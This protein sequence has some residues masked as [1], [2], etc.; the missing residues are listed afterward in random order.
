MIGFRIDV[1][2]ITERAPEIDPVLEIVSSVIQNIDDVPIL[3]MSSEQFTQEEI[4]N[5][6]EIS[7][8]LEDVENIED[9]SNIISGL[10][11]TI[12]LGY[13]I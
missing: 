5:S 10:Y 7:I 1:I 8:N 9:F 4:V 11:N 13:F 2:S 6:V 3:I 12:L